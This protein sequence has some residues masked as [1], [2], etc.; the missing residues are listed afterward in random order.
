M[1]LVV[2]TSLARGPFVTQS[3]ARAAAGDGHETDFTQTAWGGDVEFSRGYYVARVETIVSAW[4]LPIVRSPALTLPLRA[5][6]TS[7]EGRYKI[8]PGLY[9]AARFDHLGF[10]DVVG[11]SETA[12]WEAPV[13]RVEV[14]AGYSFYRNLLLKVSVQRNTRAAGRLARQGHFGAMQLVWWF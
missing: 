5:V 14:G 11:T 7:I 8:R 9:A 12:P 3:A 10:S 1:G 13:T 4:R 6:S 2:G